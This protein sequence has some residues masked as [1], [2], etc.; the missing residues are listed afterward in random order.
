MDYQIFHMFAKL[1]LYFAKIYPTKPWIVI[2]YTEYIDILVYGGLERSCC[3][4]E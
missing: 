3:V 1:A 4:K 2:C